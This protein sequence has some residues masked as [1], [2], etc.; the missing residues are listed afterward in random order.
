M[1]ELAFLGTGTM[2]LPMARNL[3]KQDFSVHAWNRSRERAA[4]SE[5]RAAR[6]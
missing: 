2:G 1:T 6:H 4:D 5:A 3:A